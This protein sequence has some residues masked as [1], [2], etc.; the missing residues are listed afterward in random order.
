MIDDV[1]R[2]DYDDYLAKHINAVKQ[3]FSWICEN[4]PEL[5][6]EYDADVLGEVISRHDNSKWDDEEY[7]AYCEYFYGEQTPEVKELFDYA[8]LRHQHN[9][10]HHWQHWVLREDSGNLKALEMPYMDV[11]E[12]VCDHWAFSWVKGDLHEIFEWYDLNK[13]KM[14]LHTN[15]KKLYE[16]ILDKIEGKLNS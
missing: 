9:N 5:V 12:M 8:W 2:D 10:P 11:I 6:D 14:V 15:T 3:A 16:S 7:F 4:L 13:E 1:M